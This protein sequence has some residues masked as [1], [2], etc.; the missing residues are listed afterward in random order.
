M[1]KLLFIAVMLI[2]AV[3][4][5]GAQAEIKFDKVNF[6]FGTFSEKNGVQK[7]SFTFTNTGNKPLVI[8]QIVASC[9]CTTPNYDKKP[10]APGQKG[11]VDVVYNGNENPGSSESRHLCYDMTWHG[12]WRWSQP[13]RRV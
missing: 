11:K 7:T 6:N 8:N 9:G 1:K 10:I 3:A 2:G 13:H 4:N 12:V 5:A